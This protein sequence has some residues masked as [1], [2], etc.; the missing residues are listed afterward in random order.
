MKKIIVTGGSGFIGSNLVNFLIKKKHGDSAGLPTR[1]E[2]Q[3]HG[4]GHPWMV[5]PCKFFLGSDPMS[6]LTKKFFF[7]KN[8]NL[9]SLLALMCKTEYP[10]NLYKNL[11]KYK[12]SIN[13]I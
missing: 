1:S 10:K 3:S 2:K 5:W 6:R 7:K 11:G 9:D 4:A 8:S 12:N 13:N